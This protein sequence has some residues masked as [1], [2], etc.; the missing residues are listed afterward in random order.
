MEAGRLAVLIGEP[1]PAE[2][3][4]KGAVLRHDIRVLLPCGDEHGGH[5]GGLRPFQQIF[6]GIRLPQRLVG[7]HRAGH[8]ADLPLIGMLTYFTGLNIMQMY[9]IGQ[10]TELAKLTLAYHL[11]RK[12]KWLVNLTE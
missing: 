9:L 1:A 11:V 6:G 3:I 10:M 8:V 2:R 7:V 12:E 4:P 5:P